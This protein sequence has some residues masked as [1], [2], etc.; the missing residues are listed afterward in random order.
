MPL[1]AITS[2]LAN[3]TST[4]SSVTA[5]V[6]VK[7]AGARGHDGCV[8][9]DLGTLE[10]LSE[11]RQRLAGEASL[12]VVILRN[13]S[14]SKAGVAQRTANVPKSRRRVLNAA[15][16]DRHEAKT[17]TTAVRLELFSLLL[18]LL[19]LEKRSPPARALGDRAAKLGRVESGRVQRGVEATDGSRAGSPPRA[20]GR[21]EQFVGQL[22]GY[23]ILLVVKDQ[24]RV[25]VA[26]M[27]DTLA[28]QPGLGKPAR[29]AVHRPS[30][31][32]DILT[33]KAGTVEG[34]GGVC[35]RAVG[36]PVAA[37]EGLGD[38]VVSTKSGATERKE[39]ARGVD[40]A[41]HAHTEGARL[42]TESLGNRRGEGAVA[43]GVGDAIAVEGSGE[44][45][46]ED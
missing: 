18:L 17:A 26:V 39:G 23:V 11:R 25:P 45:G 15:P 1:Q 9:A 13:E 29:A 43:G 19:A 33:T 3:D 37:E 12:A 40:V 36:E 31:K 10:L 44:G 24:I 42:Q 20:F 14:A 30:A 21:G 6:R 16:S 41:G 35:G 22:P 28:Q 34:G 5:Q 2:L 38:V 8:L 27:G 4:R 46:V 7:A 32:T